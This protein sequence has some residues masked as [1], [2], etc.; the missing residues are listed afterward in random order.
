MILDLHKM[1]LGDADAP[2]RERRASSA[3]KKHEGSGT[4]RHL[5]DVDDDVGD[6]DNAERRR[7]EQ[8]ELA[9]TARMVDSYF[10]IIF[11]SVVMSLPCYE[12]ARFYSR[13]LR[14][15]KRAKRNAR[16]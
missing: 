3:G 2:D 8:E 4:T 13:V 1:P 5:F 10:D 12:R 14:K 9:E 15:R 6:D 7:G 11:R 16:K